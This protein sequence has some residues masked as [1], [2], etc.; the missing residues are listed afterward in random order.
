MIVYNKIAY[1]GNI[2]CHPQYILQLSYEIYVVITAKYLSVLT[3]ILFVFSPV[4][5]FDFNQVINYIV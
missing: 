4:D 3:I 1:I 2:I 5:T